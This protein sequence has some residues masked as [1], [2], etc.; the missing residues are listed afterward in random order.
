MGDYG[1]S[2]I[3]ARVIGR[4]DKIEPKGQLTDP[5]EIDSG[6]KARL[7]TDMDGTIDAADL[8]RMVQ[9]A[10]TMPADS[11]YRTTVDKAIAIDKRLHELDA[12]IYRI[13]AEIKPERES[14]DNVCKVVGVGVAVAGLALSL[15]FLTGPLGALAALTIGVIGAGFAGYFVADIPTT[16]NVGIDSKKLRQLDDA[17]VLYYNTKKEEQQIWSDLGYYRAYRAWNNEHG[18]SASPL[19]PG[20]TPPSSTSGVGS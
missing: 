18:N 17:Q 14:R 19:A 8:D 12:K 11:N 4:M 3:G 15:L 7:D 9:A 20:L 16:T 1:A 13:K 10:A 6:G 2:G 5:I